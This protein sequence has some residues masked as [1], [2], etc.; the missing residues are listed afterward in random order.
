MGQKQTKRADLKIHMAKT[1]ST[2]VGH[3]PMWHPVSI[4]LPVSQT[5][6]KNHIFRVSEHSKVYKYILE[7]NLR[8]YVE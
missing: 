1:I 7:E 8:G 6:E 4:S 5:R 2:G 3:M